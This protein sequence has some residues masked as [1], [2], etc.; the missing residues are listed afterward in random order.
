MGQFLVYNDEV[1]FEFLLCGWIQNSYLAFTDCLKR[2]F[3]PHL[4][5]QSFRENVRVSNVALRKVAYKDPTV[6]LQ[7]YR[8]LVDLHFTEDKLI[9]RLHRVNNVI[10]LNCY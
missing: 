7:L 3:V 10:L 6:N 2:G 1:R 5:V 8:F 9:A 4:K